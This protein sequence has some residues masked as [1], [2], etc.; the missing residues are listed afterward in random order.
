MPHFRHQSII[1][2]E[3]DSMQHVSLSLLNEGIVVSQRERE[4]ERLRERERECCCCCCCSC[5]LASREYV[6]VLR[7]C[8]LSLNRDPPNQAH[9]VCETLTLSALV[10]GRPCLVSKYPHATL[11]S[12]TPPTPT[13]PTQPS[14]SCSSCGMIAREFFHHTHT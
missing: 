1:I 7:Y 6:R 10:E 4:R 9:S 2:L 12:S 3:R 5:S 8:Q 14:S 11:H 13:I